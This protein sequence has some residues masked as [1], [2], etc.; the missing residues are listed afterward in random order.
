MPIRTFQGNVKG[1]IGERGHTGG[2]G[3]EGRGDVE[4]VSG[5][6][7]RHTVLQTFLCDLAKLVNIQR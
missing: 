7:F 4:K 5:A 2:W 1:N 3:G 6:S